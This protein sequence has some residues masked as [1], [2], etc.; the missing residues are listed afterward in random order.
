MDREGGGSVY[1][2]GESMDAKQYKIICVGDSMVGKTSLIQRYMN[3][4]FNEHG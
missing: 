4:I 2:S 3:Q 1:R